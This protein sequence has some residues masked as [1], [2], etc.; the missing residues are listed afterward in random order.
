M[1]NNL[2]KYTTIDW[3]RAL[4]MLMPPVLRKKKHASWLQVLLTPLSN[5]Y[6]DTLYKMQHTGQV[7][8]LEKVLNELFNKERVYDPNL[9]TRQK[10]DLGLIFI[11]DANRPKVQYLYTHPEIL[12]GADSIDIYTRNEEDNDREFNSFLYL[13]SDL[14]FS[15]TEY[16]NFRIN[17]PDDI[18][19]TTNTYLNEVNSMD[20]VSYPIN[21]KQ[22]MLETMSDALVYD[23][24]QAHPYSPH[25]DAVKIQ[26]PR[27]HKVVN[28][29]K[30]VAKSYET[31]KYTYKNSEVPSLKTRQ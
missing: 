11:D 30:L 24:N 25:P 14:D 23:E 17:I 20:M 7:V 16:F 22:G 1:E 26:T 13:S 31:R 29:Y 3:K 15:T 4:I 28:F 10:A 19:K 9:S 12:E 2:K 21:K 18:L 8:Y 6:D 27:F 5:I